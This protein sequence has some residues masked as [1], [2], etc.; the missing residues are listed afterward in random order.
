MM[1]LQTQHIHI[2]Y[3]FMSIAFM[4]N[5]MFRYLDIIGNSE[6]EVCGQSGTSWQIRKPEM[7]QTGKEFLKY[8]NIPQ[9][10]K[11]LVAH[12]CVQ[13]K[14]Q[15]KAG[16]RFIQ[17]DLLCV[18]SSSGLQEKHPQRRLTMLLIL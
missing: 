10:A 11:F 3:Q 6:C 12:K 4:R 7:P 18:V 5:I 1:C 16:V 13:K 9:H 8:R 2:V 17:L 15:Q 14:L